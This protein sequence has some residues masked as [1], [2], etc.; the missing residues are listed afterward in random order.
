MTAAHNRDVGT[1]GDV[2]AV[3]AA[4]NEAWNAHD[5]DA[6][7]D[8]VTDDCV[9]E[10]TSPAPDGTRHVGRAAVRAAWEPIV[11]D[12]G[13]RFTAEDEPVVAGGHVVQR[14]RYDWDGGHV[15]GVD[16]IKVR[17]G[18]VAAKLSYVKG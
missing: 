17:D 8:L 2:G 10:S 9:F 16:V 6:A 14:W 15:R 5:L 18:R 7:M 3:V 4:F 13:A 11:T 1:A 12:T